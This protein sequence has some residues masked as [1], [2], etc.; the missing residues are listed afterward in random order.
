MGKCGFRLT[1]ASAYQLIPKASPTSPSDPDLWR[2]RYD[3]V[4][5]HGKISLRM[6]NHMM[7]L[8][9]GRPHTGTDVIALIH[10]LEA[11]VITHDGTVLGE[12]QLDLNR[13]YQPKQNNG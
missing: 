12:Y 10:N 6:G 1:P 4:D 11:T 13:N 3:T 2:V 7:H 5:R 8:G 9:I